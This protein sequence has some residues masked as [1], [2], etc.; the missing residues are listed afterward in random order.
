MLKFY[1]SLCADVILDG[2][3]VRETSQGT[4]AH[5][6]TV[7]LGTTVILV[8]RASGIP[9]RV[10]TSYR[11]TCRHGPCNI[12]S[13]ILKIAVISTSDGGDYACTVLADGKTSVNSSVFT[14]T[15]VEPSM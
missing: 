3:R 14:F 1:E 4:L 13:Q 11:W 7:Q 8:C 6:D 2:Y 5:T 15:A 12:G 9:Y 10:Q